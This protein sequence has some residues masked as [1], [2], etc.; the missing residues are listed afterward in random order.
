MDDIA[1]IV[2]TCGKRD[3]SAHEP[4]YGAAPDAPMSLNMTSQTR[5]WRT[6]AKGSRKKPTGWTPKPQEDESKNKTRGD[7]AEGITAPRTGPLQRSL[8]KR[9]IGMPRQTHS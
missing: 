2:Y 6:L 7:G 5:Q 3:G 4:G 8:V 9:R 1:V